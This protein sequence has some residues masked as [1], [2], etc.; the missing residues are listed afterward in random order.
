M[1]SNEKKFNLDGPDGLQYYWHDPKIESDSFSARVS[2]GG[3][4]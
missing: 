4:E 3:G 2:G 1:F